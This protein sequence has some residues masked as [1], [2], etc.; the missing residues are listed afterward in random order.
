MV[1]I[2]NG[3]CST[4]ISALVCYILH[5]FELIRVFTMSFLYGLVQ[6]CQNFTGFF[7]LLKYV[8]QRFQAK[9]N[10]ELYF[11]LKRHFN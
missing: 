1:F 8:T 10:Q 4:D 5:Y 7:H 3:T 11:I 9:K 2:I 6:E